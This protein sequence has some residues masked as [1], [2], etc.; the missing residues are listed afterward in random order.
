[1]EAGPVNN[2]LIVIEVCGEEFGLPKGWVCEMWWLEG[3]PEGLAKG[4]WAERGEAWTGGVAFR[5]RGAKEKRR[6]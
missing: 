1:M 2:G 5:A 3:E 4:V 6:S